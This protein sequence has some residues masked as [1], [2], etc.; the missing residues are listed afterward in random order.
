MCA[1]AHIRAEHPD[2]LL[3][4]KVISSRRTLCIIASI[5]WK[6]LGAAAMRGPC[7]V[8]GDL[9]AALNGLDEILATAEQ[10]LGCVQVAPPMQLAMIGTLLRAVSPH[11]IEA[12]INQYKYY[13]DLPLRSF[14][15]E[16]N[17]TAKCRQR[18]IGTRPEGLN[19]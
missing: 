14:T 12:S 3:V 17:E 6:L 11:P 2:T 10:N 16:P 8:T 4:R 1:T 9:D 7:L 13:A 15:P 18:R 5:R 19:V